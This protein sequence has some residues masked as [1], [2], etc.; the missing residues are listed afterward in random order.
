MAAGI[1]A[2]SNHGSLLLITERA[3]NIH[4][5]RNSGRCWGWRAYWSCTHRS[6]KFLEAIDCGYKTRTIRRAETWGPQR[7]DALQLCVGMSTPACEKIRDVTCTRVRPV[8][9]DH[10]GVVLDGRPLYA[11]DAR[12][13]QGGPQPEAYDGDFARADGFDSFSDMVDFFEKQYGCHSWG[14]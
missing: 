3:P 12:A 4:A 8:T 11:G 2:Q 13:Y 9:I 7:G 1:E 5:L 10:I 6:A 14:N